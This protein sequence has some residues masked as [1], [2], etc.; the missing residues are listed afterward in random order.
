M[1]AEILSI[2]DE[3][4]IGQVINTNQAFIAERLNS[5][6]VSVER[7]V[8]VG[9]GVNKIVRAF[10]EAMARHDVVVATGGLGPTHDDVTR[11]AVCELFETALVR[12]EEAFQNVLRIF[13][14]RGR[15]VL[16][17][18]EEQALVPQG[19]TVI[20][21]AHG[22]APGYFFSREG[23][24]VAVLPGVPYEMEAMVENFIVPYFRARTTG[25]VI[26]H[27]TLLTTGIAEST[28]AH[29]LGPVEELFQSSD[30]IT[31]AFLPSALGVRLRLTARSASAQA[32]QAVLSR[33]ETAIRAKA[34]KYIYG[35]DTQTMEQVVGSLLRQR[36]LTVAVA[37]SC[38]GGLVVDRLT[39]VPGSSEYVERGFITYSNRSKTEEL[40]VPA[41]TIAKAGAVSQEVAQAMARGARTVAG[42]DIGVSTTGIAG[43]G[44]ATESKPVG[45]LWIGY[46]DA[47]S[48]FALKFQLETDRRRFK[49]RASQ[50]A[51]DLLRRRLLKID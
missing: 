47:D 5:V 1:N 50:A 20:Q 32:A 33:V 10:R 27:R 8:T 25:S 43:P 36:K 41:E 35:T 19:C 44:G 15:P 46:A 30:G 3:L 51:L 37:E 16:P 13:A 40:K 21:N 39:D 26:V 17:V 48:S 45:T 24:I 22:T 12:D 34:E 6:G 29:T 38:T 11:R 7:M 42:T 23:K 4:L 14:S 2:G 31:L 9:D 18:N 49:V 28:L